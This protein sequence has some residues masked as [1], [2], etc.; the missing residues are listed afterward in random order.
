MKKLLLSIILLVGLTFQAQELTTFEGLWKGE[1]SSYY[2]AIMENE[3][4]F[5]FNDFSFEQGH[6][7][8]EN[9]VEVGENY[10]ITTIGYKPTNWEVTI[11]YTV[12]DED[13]LLCEFSGSSNNTSLYNR[14]KLN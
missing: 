10:I 3:G 1:R 8:I 11:K 12:V 14:V 5:E 7:V 9:V 4:E 6:S 2:V 13:T